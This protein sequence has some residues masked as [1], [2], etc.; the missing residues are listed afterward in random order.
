MVPAF[1]PL[2]FHWYTGVEPPFTGVAVKVTADPGQNGLADAEIVIPAGRLAFTTMVTGFDC[3]GF[4]EVQVSEDN[5]EQV[6]T[7]PLAGE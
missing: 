1:V 7:S 6:T 4:P 2:T 3:A 5:N